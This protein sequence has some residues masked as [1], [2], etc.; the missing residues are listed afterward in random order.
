MKLSIV[1]PTYNR[2]DL[3][4][5]ALES[6]SVSWKRCAPFVGKE[7]EV[8][9]VDDGNDGTPGIVQA[10]KAAHPEILVSYIRPE[11]RKGVNQARNIGAKHATG[12]WI[13]FLDSDDEYVETGLGEIFATLASVPF[14]IR[15]LGFM[16]LRENAEGVME[17]RG[18][19]VGGDWKTFRPSY[20]DVLLKTNIRGD[21]H[22]VCNKDIFVQ[23]LGFPEDVQGFELSFFARIAKQGMRFLYINKVVDRR[24]MGTHEHIGSYAKWPKQYAQGYVAY[25]HEHENALK[26]HPERLAYYYRSTGSAYL[27]AYDPRCLYWYLRYLFVKLFG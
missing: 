26:K 7:I 3:I 5:R 22:Y 19:D 4:G 14:D 21:I 16:T 2:A 23:G 15:V 12:E 24:H 9:V 6:I 18:Y 27:R 10:W 13:A 25:L 8:I 17:P 20:E 1:I 11:K